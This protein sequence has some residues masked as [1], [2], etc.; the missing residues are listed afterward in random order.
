MNSMTIHV[1]REFW[2]HR[3]LY[4]APLVW[5]A[6]I[7]LVAAWSIFVLIPNLAEHHGVMLSS[8]DKALSQL[9]DSDRQAAEAAIA[10]AKNHAGSVVQAK[11]AVF[12]FSFVAVTQMVTGLAIIVVFFYLLDCLYSER[13]DRS[14]LFWKSLPISDAQVV[15]AKLV[16]ALVVVP[17]GAILLAGVMELLLVAM[18]WLRFHDTVVGPVVSD[19]S[20]LTWVK[21]QGVALVMGLGGVMWYAPIAGYLLLVSSW[22][23]RNVFLWAV[24]PPVALGF[25][26]WFFI[27]STKVFE[28]IG[29]RFGGY[30][31]K[32]R[33]DTDMMNVGTRD[34]GKDLRHVVDMLTNIDYSR[35]FLN[36]E[37]WI[38]MVAA[39]ALVYAAIRM[40]RYRD[41]S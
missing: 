2:E 32:L 5:A 15:V 23:R 29:W 41:E 39:A 19:W 7:T 40:R 22:A 13:R 11:E 34:G 10:E 14:I 38:G 17:L 24:L 9:D 31:T 37:V 18:F 4:I 28:F 6:V 27:H 3:S 12:R 35:L 33:V 36:S 26:E 16:V 20:L 30:V 8:P 1:R 21:S 25:L